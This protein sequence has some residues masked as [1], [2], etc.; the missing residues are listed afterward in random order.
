VFFCLLAKN[1]LNLLLN[2]LNMKDKIKGSKVLNEQK[3]YTWVEDGITITVRTVK[4]FEFIP[5][6][7]E[8]KENDFCEEVINPIV[9]LPYPIK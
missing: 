7:I 3:E 5:S 2:K 1:V 8:P 6:D 4:G 9:F